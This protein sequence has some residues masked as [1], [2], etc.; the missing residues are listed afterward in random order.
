MKNLN[1]H[2]SRSSSVKATIALALLALTALPATSV[3]A[4]DELIGA[5]EYRTSCLACHGAGGRGDGP[6]AKYLNV[7]PTDLTQITKNNGGTF[8]LIKTMHI[9]DGRGEVRG[10]GDRTMPIWGSRYKAEQAGK[11]GP[12]GGEWQVRSR[13]LE[14]VFYLQ[15]IQQ[16]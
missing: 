11:Y 1:Y 10:H 13:V 4:E 8:P 12:Y 15:Q 9:I 7:K 3:R 2:S 16:K 14:L 6:M 5:E